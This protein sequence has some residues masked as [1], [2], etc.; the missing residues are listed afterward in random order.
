M[1]CLITMIPKILQSLLT[2]K[3]GKFKSY[4]VIYMMKNDKYNVCKEDIDSIDYY[5]MKIP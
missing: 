1:E 3:C 5:Y 4:D 2:T